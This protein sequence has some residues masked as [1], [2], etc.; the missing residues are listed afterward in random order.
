MSTILKTCNKQFI[1]HFIVKRKF[2]FFIQVFLFLRIIVFLYFFI[3]FHLSSLNSTLYL[4]LAL[5]AQ[6]DLSAL[7]ITPTDICS[8]K[9][10]CRNHDFYGWCKWRHE[11]KTYSESQGMCLH[12]CGD[13]YFGGA[14]WNQLCCLC[15][16]VC[17]WGIFCLDY[18]LMSVMFG[19]GEKVTH[20][21]PKFCLDCY[22]SLSRT[23][24]SII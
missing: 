22:L 14:L 17:Q 18:L 11:G 9:P 6:T 10:K 12:M 4:C 20:P 23:E 1:F 15:G 2:N 5:K 21:I 7:L 24:S 3:Y 19:F 16:C 13:V 8:L